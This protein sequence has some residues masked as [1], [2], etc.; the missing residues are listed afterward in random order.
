MVKTM[1]DKDGCR[2]AA[3]SRKASS[4]CD[5]RAQ[6]EQRVNWC[7]NNATCIGCTFPTFPDGSPLFYVNPGRFPP[8]GGNPPGCAYSTL[9]RGFPFQS[10]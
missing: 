3:Y 7:V 1:S 10:L 6:M 9:Q 8:G 2:F 4:A 5:L